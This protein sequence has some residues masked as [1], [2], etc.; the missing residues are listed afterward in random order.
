MG[1]IGQAIVKGRK[2]P[3]QE[4]G[5]RRG[6]CVN[7][8]TGH[9]LFQKDRLRGNEWSSRAFVSRQFFGEHKQR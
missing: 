3:E 6:I 1:G 5:G 2:S 7:E 9:P 4:G 8:R